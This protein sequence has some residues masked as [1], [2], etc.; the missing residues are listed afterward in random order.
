MKANR[1]FLA[2][3]LAPPW[4][5]TAIE[6]KQAISL[7]GPSVKAVPNNAAVWQ[8]VRVPRWSIWVLQKRI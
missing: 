7:I 4:A 6:G 5:G 1:Q 8:C 3:K 2:S